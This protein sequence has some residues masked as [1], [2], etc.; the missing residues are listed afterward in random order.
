MARFGGFTLITFV[1]YLIFLLYTC[2]IMGMGVLLEKTSELDSVLCRKITHVL[3]AGLWVICYVFFGFSLHWL[4]LNLLST[5]VLAFTT[6]SKKVR[7]FEK[8]D[9]KNSIGL[10]YFSLSTSIVAL[11]CYFMGEEFYLYTGVAYFCLTLGDGLA[12]IVAKVLEKHNLSLIPGKSLFGCLTVFI[13]SVLSTCVFSLVFDMHLPVMMILSVAG[14]TCVAEFYGVKGLDNIMIEFSVFGYMLLY[15]FDMVSAPLQLVLILSPFLASVALYGKILSYSGGI[16]ALWLFTCIGFFSKGFLPIGFITALF[17]LT[18]LV[19]LATKK[20]KKKHAHKGDHSA[21]KFKQILAVGLF[22]LVF[23]GIYRY[24]GIW[25][26]KLIFYLSLA[27][28]F[29]DSMAS[30]IGSLTKGKNVSIMNFK[31]VEKGIS[32]GVSVLGT[33]SA[34]FASFLI[35]VIP[36]AFGEIGVLTYFV[37]SLIAFIGVMLDSV[38]GAL[39]QSLYVCDMCNLK[40]E[41]S[42]HCGQST[43][44]IK[45]YR[46]VDNVSVN[47]ITGLVTCLL[48]GVL[49]LI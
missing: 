13:V 49:F 23:L 40:T 25:T 36:L 45:G 19:A 16:A 30:D 3:S 1:G 44:L 18:G 26:F 4:I 28:Q 43:R 29:A 32:G 5:V 41:E 12:P 8:D 33:A 35:M 22:S 15:H 24:S 47:F 9:S 20:L 34:L 11:V 39:F 17:L 46:F 10:F 2:A 7:F 6:F 37:I 31:T 21:R 38:I 27:E 48:G 14:L 42:V